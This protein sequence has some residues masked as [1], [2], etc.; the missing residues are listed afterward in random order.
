MTCS[1]DFA[2]VLLSLH[3]N[4]PPPSLLLSFSCPLSR[5]PWFDHL[6]AHRNAALSKCFLPLCRIELVNGEEG[7]EAE[8]E[9]LE[10]DAEWHRD[11]PWAQ[12]DTEFKGKKVYCGIPDDQDIVEDRV[13][14]V[15]G[16]L[17]LSEADFTDEDGQNQPLWRI[18]FGPTVI[19]PDFERK[20]VVEG[21]KK[22]KQYKR[23]EEGRDGGP[24]W[25][26]GK[27]PELATRK[28]K[29]IERKEMEKEKDELNEREKQKKRK[30]AVGQSG[31]DIAAKSGMIT[32][33]SRVSSCPHFLCD[34]GRVVAG[35][36][37]L[38]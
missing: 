14:T 26:A 25:S 31:N 23:V 38:F 32:V 8:A 20:D 22:Y 2:L 7:R 5:C 12:P 27:D 1:F 19:K 10:V 30:Y 4:F 37:G 36:M 21:I 24:A 6:P 16:W 35:Y 11:Q 17:P 28:K 13:G 9:I 34:C 33:C 18:D 15:W 3:C 29:D